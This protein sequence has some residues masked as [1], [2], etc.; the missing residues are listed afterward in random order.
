[1]HEIKLVKRFMESPCQSRLQEAK[2]ILLYIK[3]IQSHDI[4]YTYILIR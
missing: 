1:M 4:F 3:D 2:R